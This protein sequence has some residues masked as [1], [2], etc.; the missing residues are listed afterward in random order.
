M[1]SWLKLVKLLAAEG[2]GGATQGPTVQ[3]AVFRILLRLLYKR[4]P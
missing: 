4:C 1:A 2:D 3:G